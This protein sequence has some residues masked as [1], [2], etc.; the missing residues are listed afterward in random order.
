MTKWYSSKT[1]YRSET[2][3]VYHGAEEMKAW[4]TELF[5]SFE[6]NKHIPE[7]YVQ[8]KVDGATKIH[9]GFRRLLWIKGNTGPEP[10]T[11]TPVA[12][13]CEIG[14]ADDPDAYLGLQFKTSSI[15]WDKT[16][17]VAL[18]KKKLPSDL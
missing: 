6:A 5:Y 8:Y 4:M 2:G 17:T 12:W 1:V 7:Y 9:V 11:D 18:L 10:D 13:I 14:P 16:Q 15:H 3:K